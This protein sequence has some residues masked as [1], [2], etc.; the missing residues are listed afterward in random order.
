MYVCEHV[1]TCV[2]VWDGS[3][4]WTVYVWD[5]CCDVGKCLLFK[6]KCDRCWRIVD[7]FGTL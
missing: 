3:I 2:K 5:E 1:W 7:V 4:I 6:M